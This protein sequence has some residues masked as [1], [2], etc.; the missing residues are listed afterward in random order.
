MAKQP[1][2]NTD[3]TVNSVAL[4][5][6][7]TGWS[8]DMSQETPVVTS[9]A[10]AG[11]RRVVGNYDYALNLDG[12]ADFAASQSDATLFGLIGSTGV[13]LDLEPTGANSGTDD[14][15]YTSTS[16]VLNSY[17]IAGQVGGAVTFRA[18]M[19]GNAAIARATA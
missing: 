12:V 2:K 13:A 19:A 7:V 6:D 1:A 14:P 11:P 4:E 18:A 17:S 3:I 9:L 15:N 5:D 10:D 16:I 8:F